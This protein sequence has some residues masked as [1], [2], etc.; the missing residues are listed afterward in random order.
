MLRGLSIVSC[1]WA[2]NVGIGVSNPTHKLHVS[3]G[4]VRVEGLSGTGIALVG[5]SPSGVTERIAFSGSA[6]DFFRG[7][8]TWGPDPGDWNLSGNATTNPS[9]HFLGTTD[10]QSL[11][12]RTNNAERMRFLVDG[13]ILVGTTSPLHS[14][15]VLQVLGGNTNRAVYGWKSS[16][17]GVSV[18]LG[19]ATASGGVRAGAIGYGSQSSIIGTTTLGVGLVGMVGVTDFLHWDMGP[20]IVG[21]SINHGVV[22]YAENT[23]GDRAA[24][25][26]EA[27][28]SANQ[29]ARALVAAFIGGTQY[30]IWGIVT[31]G[32]TFTPPGTS[33]VIQGPEGN[34][35]ALVCPEAPEIYL[36][37]R[38]EA[39]FQGGQ[40]VVAFD[41]ALSF[42]LYTDSQYPMY[43]FVQPI[44][45]DCGLYVSERHRGGFVVKGTE[46]ECETRF[47]WWAVARRND[48]YTPEGLR[49][50]RHVG[51][52]LPIVPPNLR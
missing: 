27:P 37:D 44:D 33:T 6:S 46:E 24:G 25:C 15:S 42:N 30:K 2:Q 38:G 50:S 12:L 11:H 13:R 22:A 23:S 5:L 41:P 40:G 39:L 14:T 26:F 19:I 17:N 3:G 36:M 20:G 28:V 21:S 8:G 35:Y 47:Y 49:I 32:G 29:T 7:D 48:T 45:R 16:S 52:R 34:R 1:L 51:V 10:A 9:I 18:V 31:G 4:L 43:V